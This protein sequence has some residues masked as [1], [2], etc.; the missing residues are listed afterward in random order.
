MLY[1]NHHLAIQAIYK[2]IWCIVGTAS[3]R[4][5]ENLDTQKENKKNKNIER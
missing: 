2:I 3:M 4:T 1:N 5:L